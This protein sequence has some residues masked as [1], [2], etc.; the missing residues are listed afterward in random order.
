MY[1]LSDQ[2]D[3]WMPHKIDTTLSAMPASDIPTLL[4][5]SVKTL[6]GKVVKPKMYGFPVN[7]MRNKFQGCT[8]CLNESLRDLVSNTDF[9]NAIMHDWWI[10]LLATA[11]GKIKIEKEP[12]VTYR[13]HEKNTVGF[14]NFSLKVKRY[15]HS[16]VR[17]GSRKDMYLQA[18][19]LL[20]Y[21]RGEDYTAIK[22]WMD[23][24]NSP[25]LKRISYVLTN[26]RIFMADFSTF[27]LVPLIVSGSYKH[28]SIVNIQEHH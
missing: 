16:L 5:S 25:A 26:L 11:Q 17:Q 12:L 10:V 19:S 27:G 21:A 18:E 15:V 24:V 9:G 7:L 8:F 14:P 4:A 28:T 1:F 20:P 2:D 23:S 13:I 3:V 22:L 6:R